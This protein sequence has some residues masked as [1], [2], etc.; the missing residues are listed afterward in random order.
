MSLAWISSYPK[1]GNTWV[2]ILLA[3]YRQ[4]RKVRLR[5]AGDGFKNMDDTDP[6][7]YDLFAEGRM[8]PLDDARVLTVKTHLLASAEILRPYRDATHRVLY[9]IRNPRDIIPS[10]ERFLQISAERRAAF[11]EHFVVHRGW[12]GWRKVGFGTWPQ[13]VLEW[14]SRDEL[15][16][17]FPRAELCVLRYEDIKRDP[18]TSLYT[19]VEFLRLDTVPDLGRVRRAVEHSALDRLRV[20]ERPNPHKPKFFG[21][22]LSGQSLTAYGAEVEDA[23][24]RLLRDDPQFAACAERFGYAEGAATQL[25]A[26]TSRP[27]K[28]G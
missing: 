4:D 26:A 15:R 8:L 13:H 3:S 24:R 21:Q 12:Q 23:Y 17:Y 27:G 10:A 16:K 9:L 11:A 25:P 6:D 19:M 28:E 7:L 14:T 2:R 5:W 20:A 18:V 1:S 22:G